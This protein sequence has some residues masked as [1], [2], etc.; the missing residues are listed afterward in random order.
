VVKNDA[1]IKGLMSKIE[2]LFFNNNTLEADPE[3]YIEGVA[4]DSPSSLINSIREMRRR[5]EEEMNA[6]HKR[7]MEKIQAQ[8]KMAKEQQELL[9]KQKME[10]QDSINQSNQQEALIR[11]LGGIQTDNNSDG[12]IDAMQNL[13]NKISQIQGQL[14]LNLQKLEFDKTKHEDQMNQKDKELLAK[15]SIEQKKLA[16]A[17]ANSQKSDDKQLNKKIANKQGVI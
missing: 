8:E 13:Q 9:H 15:Q 1:F 4:G 11:A 6:E 3:V 5:R 12:Q 14:N 16:V 10:L 7:E 2:R 17:I